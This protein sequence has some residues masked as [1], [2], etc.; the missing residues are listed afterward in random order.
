MTLIPVEPGRVPTKNQYE[1][2]RVLADPALMLVSGI[3]GDRR[4]WLSL[5]KHGWVAPE[6]PERDGENGLRI[7]PAGLRALAAYLERDPERGLPALAAS[8]SCRR[9]P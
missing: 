2:L 4:T 1:R 9:R 8:A 6:H 5:L 3:G 7:T